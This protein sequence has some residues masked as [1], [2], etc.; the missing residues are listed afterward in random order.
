MNK[1]NTSHQTSYYKNTKNNS[2]NGLLRLKEYSPK[3]QFAQNSSDRCANNQEALTAQD[4]EH[5]SIRKIIS[6]IIADG[7]KA[8]LI[9]N[10]RSCDH[11]ANQSLNTHDKEPRSIAEIVS[12]EM[13]G[14]AKIIALIN[15]TKVK[16]EV[17]PSGTNR[18]A[19]DLLMQNLIE[20]SGD[21]YCVASDFSSF[22]RWYNDT[23][24]KK[25]R[26]RQPV[27]TCLSKKLY[28][29]SLGLLLKQS[30][31]SLSNQKRRRA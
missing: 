14:K 10:N 29:V 16:I 18:T 17:D 23:F 3:K 21:T 26:L 25:S 30:Q 15:G 6:Y 7:G 19:K 13:V 22:Q 20:S 5:E 4:S 27:D 9:N 31:F 1:Q 11:I 28:G 24:K 12:L 8:E 2:T